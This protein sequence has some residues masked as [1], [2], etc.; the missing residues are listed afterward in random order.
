MLKQYG[1]DERGSV[2]VMVAIILPALLGFVALVAEFGFGFVVKAENQRIADLA[3][4]AGAAAYSSANS[5]ADMNAAVARIAVLNGI[6]STA[7]SASLINSPRTTGAQAVSVLVSTDRSLFLAPVVSDTS[8]LQIR[9]SA[10]AELPTASTPGCVIALSSSETGVTLSGGTAISA[11]ACAVSSNNT[12]TVPCGTTITAKAVNYN[13][14]AAPSQPCSGIQSPPGLTV[15]ITKTSTTD[16]LASEPSVTAA[17]GRLSTV[18]SQTITTFTAASVASGTNVD[19]PWWNDTSYFSG[20]LP[21]GC[22]ASYQTSGGPQG[23]IISCNAGGSYNFGNFTIQNGVKLQAT[24]GN[25]TGKATYNFKG[26]LK[27]NN[28]TF[29]FGPGT[30]NFAKDVWITGGSTAKFSVG[31][32]STYVMSQGIKTDG[33]TT[34]TFGP[35][36][37]K[38]GAL[39]AA[40]SGQLY[41]V[42]HTGTTLTFDGPSTFLIT[43]GIYNNGGSTMRFGGT[44]TTNTY[45]IGS[46]SSGNAMVLG[47]GATTKFADAAGTVFKVV[48]N[49]NVVSGGGSCLTLPAATNHDIKGYVSTAGGTKFGAGVYTIRDYMAFGMS[50][51]GNVTCDGSSIGVLADNV[52]MVIGGSALP[53][54]GTCSGQAFC[55]GAGYSSVVITAPTATKLAVIGPTGSGSAGAT[56]TQGASGNSISGAFYFPRGPI[57]MSGGAHIGNGSG[58][59]LQMIGSRVT[60]SGGTTAASACIT[61]TVAGS[62]SVMLV[63]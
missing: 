5:S 28:G 43:A 23:W 42:C 12:V 15:K 44:A 62:G 20:K 47:G 6:A 29:E 58:Q 50:G 46:P 9:A 60:L 39:T 53:S 61:T 63:N 57:L 54:S 22:T 31:V 52:T 51:G 33:G 48:G 16:P 32:T 7:A 1:R 37:F 41:S 11:P 45:E 55:V 36:N 17:T 59:C 56:L 40:C 19:F 25:G 27:V 38:I 18:S 30:Y 34:T 49:I 13:S 3:A 26:T 2:S 8:S 35:G 24:G 14:S 4:Y 21:S 10:A